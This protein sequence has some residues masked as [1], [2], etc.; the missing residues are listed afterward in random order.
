MTLAEEYVAKVRAEIELESRAIVGGSCKTLEDYKH[1]V[2]KVAGLHM[3][4][5]ILEDLFHTKP[6]EERN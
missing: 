5:T 6:K 4:I 3:A 1:R 2:G